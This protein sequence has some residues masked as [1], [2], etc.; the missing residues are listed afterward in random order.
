MSNEYRTK[1]DDERSNRK[2]ESLRN[3]LKRYTKGIYREKKERNEYGHPRRGMKRINS[4]RIK[5]QKPK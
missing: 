4:E 5:P 1:K 3:D 2:N